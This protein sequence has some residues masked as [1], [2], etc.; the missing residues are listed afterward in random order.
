MTDHER[1]IKLMERVDSIYN[2]LTN[3]LTHHFYYSV[4]LLGIAAGAIG[5][6]AFY[7]LTH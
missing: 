6:L 1:I 4:T 7:I 5:T 2:M 3:H